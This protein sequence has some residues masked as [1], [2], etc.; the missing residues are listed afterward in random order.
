M[1]YEKKYALGNVA[2]K[3]VALT[4][5]GGYDALDSSRTLPKSMCDEVFNFAFD[6]GRLTEGIA[7]SQLR[8]TLDDGTECAVPPPTDLRFDGNMFSGKLKID[9]KTRDVIFLSETGKLH[10][11]VLGDAAAQWQTLTVNPGTYVSAVSYVFE[12]DDLMLFGGVGRGVYILSGTNGGQQVAG[13]LPI[14][15]ICSYHE[16]IFAVVEHDRP[17]VWFSDTFDPYDWSVSLEAGGYLYT[18]GAAGKVLRVAAMGDHLFVVCEYGLYRLNG[19]ADQTA[20]TFKRISSDTGRIFGGSAVVC[21]D[22]LVFAATDGIYASDGYGVYKL[23]DRAD[24]LLAGAKDMNAVFWRN[25]Y[26]ATFTDDGEKVYGHDA[27]KTENA[28]MALD[29]DSGNLDVYRNEICRSLTV[30]KGSLDNKLIARS[31]DDALVLSAD[32]KAPLNGVKLRYWHTGGIDF[33]LPCDKKRIVSVECRTSAPVTFGVVADGCAHEYELS[34]AVGRR[35]I[36][37]E[38]TTFDFYIRSRAMRVTVYPP[39]LTVD[40]TSR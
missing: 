39:L 35:L 38:G 6:K 40:V 25:S 23:T 12:D 17:C 19:Y 34:P 1:F 37:I 11:F 20:F 10:M 8:Q 2:R 21:G 13:A 18:D 7:F 22:S 15:D 24:K 9:E 28:M 26:I 33:G 32:S 4:D 3:R 27:G 29:L 36:G 30:L 14:R 16:R 5:F 31:K